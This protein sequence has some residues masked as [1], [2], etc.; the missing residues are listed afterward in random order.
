MVLAGP[1]REVGGKAPQ[2]VD[3]DVVRFGEFDLP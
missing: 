2:C 3:G 1:G